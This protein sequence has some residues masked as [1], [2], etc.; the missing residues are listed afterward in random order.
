MGPLIYFIEFLFFFNLNLPQKWMAS[1]VQ[2]PLTKCHQDI[3]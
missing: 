2:W 3:E 1:F